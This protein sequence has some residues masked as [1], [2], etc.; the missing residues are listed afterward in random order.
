M[1]MEFA[2]DQEEDLV[3]AVAAREWRDVIKRCQKYRN[4]IVTI[5]DPPFEGTEEEIYIFSGFVKP[6]R[7]VIVI[8]DPDQDAFYQRDIVVEV[9]NS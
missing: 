1:T 4:T 9:R 5:N 2:N 7:H 8:Y 6:G 3:D